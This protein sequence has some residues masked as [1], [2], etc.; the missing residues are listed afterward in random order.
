MDV[1][2][3]KKENPIGRLVKETAVVVAKNNSVRKL[4][5]TRYLVGTL[6]GLSNAFQLVTSLKKL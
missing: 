5:R 4:F 3:E 6:Y 2:T 1:K